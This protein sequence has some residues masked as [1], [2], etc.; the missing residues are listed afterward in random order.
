M[1]KK[2]PNVGKKPFGPNAIS[3]AEK[4]LKFEASLNKRFAL[5]YFWWSWWGC[6]MQHAHWQKNRKRIQSLSRTRARMQTN[7]NAHHT[8]TL[9]SALTHT[10]TQE[11]TCTHTLPWHRCSSS[12]LCWEES[13]FWWLFLRTWQ[14]RQIKRCNSDNVCNSRNNRNSNNDSKWYCRSSPCRSRRARRYWTFSLAQLSQPRVPRAVPQRRFSRDRTP[15]TVMS[16]SS[17]SSF[18]NCRALSLSSWKPSK[19]M[20][21]YCRSSSP[22]PQPRTPGRPRSLA[23]ASSFHLSSLFSTPIAQRFM[24]AQ[25]SSAWCHHSIPQTHA[26]CCSR[27]WMSKISAGTG[28]SFIRL[29]SMWSRPT[30]IPSWHRVP[31]FRHRW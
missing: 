12:S 26:W 13:R 22:P 7:L 4:Y 3:K 18:S 21:N 14:W 16:F 25:W 24:C 8:S 11:C 20:S 17:F 30:I 31:R 1:T 10:H 5:F 15:S 23:G 2:S 19:S 28:R 9:V 6:T 27:A 29:A